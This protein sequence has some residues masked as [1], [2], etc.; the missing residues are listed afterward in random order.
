M[1]S[2]AVVSN[3]LSYSIAGSNPAVPIGKNMNKKIARARQTMRKA[4]EKDEDFW[5]TYKANVACLLMDYQGDG[6]PKDFTIPEERNGLANRILKL[7][8]WP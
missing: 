2:Q 8:F 3:L 4:F 1:H 5:G 7:I 6:K